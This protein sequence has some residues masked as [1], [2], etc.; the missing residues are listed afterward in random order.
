MHEP[1][2]SPVATSSAANRVVVPWR[3]SS[4]VRHRAGPALLKR[5]PRLGAVERLDLALLVGRGHERALRRLAVEG[6]DVAHPLD[7][8]LVAREL[9]GSHRVRLEVMRLPDPLHR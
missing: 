5:Q 7:E 1:M 6:D 3:L 8:A 9:E 4:I 2:T